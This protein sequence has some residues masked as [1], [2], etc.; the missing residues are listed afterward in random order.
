MGDYSQYRQQAQLP[1]GGDSVGFCEG[2]ISRS[3]VENVPGGPR[4][5]GVL[6][7]ESNP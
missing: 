6:G 5:E 7:I 4:M 2:L 3:E 1:E